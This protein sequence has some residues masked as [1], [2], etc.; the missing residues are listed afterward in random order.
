MGEEVEKIIKGRKRLEH[1]E[2]ESEMEETGG[3]SERSFQIW[4]K[5]GIK[6]NYNHLISSWLPPKAIEPE[7]ICDS[8]K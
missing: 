3:Y 7:E 6:S 1:S 5:L 4:S 2:E 8:Q